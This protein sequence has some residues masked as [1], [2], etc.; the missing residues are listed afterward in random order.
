[1][2]PQQTPIELWHEIFQ[3]LSCQEL[4][5]A[6]S[7]SRQWDHLSSCLFLYRRLFE[8][9]FRSSMVLD[10]QHAPFVEMMLRDCDDET[11]VAHV[12]KQCFPILEDLDLEAPETQIQ[13]S[14]LQLLLDSKDRL[15]RFFSQE[16]EE[17]PE[18]ACLG[19]A[20]DMSLGLVSQLLDMADIHFSIEDKVKRCKN[21]KKFRERWRNHGFVI[22]VSA[23]TTD[24]K[25]MVIHTLHA[26]TRGKRNLLD[27][28]GNR[29]NDSL[30]MQD[31]EQLQFGVQGLLKNCNAIV[32]F[33]PNTKSLFEDKDP[34]ELRSFWDS[35]AKEI[36]AL[37]RL[38]SKVSAMA[39][40][41][42]SNRHI[43]EEN[44]LTAIEI[45]EALGRA[46]FLLEYPKPWRIFSLLSQDST[47][48]NFNQ[49]LEF[50][51]PVSTCK[52]N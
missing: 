30:I 16:Q 52:E 36:S 48:E 31:S 10:S 27:F 24:M 23:S 17:I 18:C 20:A 34:E 13:S 9:E 44:C 42:I 50:I 43:N 21:Q 11:Q 25:H 8:K 1:M 26:R 2:N 33:V 12:F 51:Y 22:N 5:K 45:F 6:S 38:N 46:P 32:Y 40:V 35:V 19:P 47:F 39:I 41:G 15:S 49:V 28:G 14:L 29:V 7:V 37:V 4:A 3:Y